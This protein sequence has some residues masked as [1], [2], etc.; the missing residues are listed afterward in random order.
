M[1]TIF[2]LLAQ[3]PAEVAWITKLLSGA[4]ESVGILIVV[5]LFLRRQRQSDRVLDR[6]AGSQEKLAAALAGKD[7]EAFQV[8]SKSFPGIEEARARVQP[9]WSGRFPEDPES[10]RIKVEDPTE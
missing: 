10:I 8:I 3:D 1:L 9:F 7:K 2:A 6:L 5:L 4:V